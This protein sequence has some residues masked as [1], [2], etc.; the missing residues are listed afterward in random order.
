MSLY[1]GDFFNYQDLIQQANIIFVNNFIFG[2]EVNRK[3][4][5]IFQDGDKTKD[6]TMII[7]TEKFCDGGQVNQR[8]A[9]SFEAICDVEE[10]CEGEVSWTSQKV[11]FWLH[12]ID[13][14]KLMK[15]YQASSS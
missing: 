13:Y 9:D 4:V 12:T 6:G 11:K 1:Q 2:A 14:S 10:L 5:E 8:N 7:S 3:L 15:Y